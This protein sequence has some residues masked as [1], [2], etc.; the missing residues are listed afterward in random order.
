MLQF[1]GMVHT[2]SVAVLAMML[3]FEDISSFLKARSYNCQLR[4]ISSETI[5]G[6]DRRAFDAPGIDEKNK[7]R[8][9][10]CERYE[11]E[12]DEVWK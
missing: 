7:N 3:W 1:G 6:H 8:K 9:R 10:E 12:H 2:V 11:R 5:S 4:V